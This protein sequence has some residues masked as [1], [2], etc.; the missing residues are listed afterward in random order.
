MTC[1]ALRVSLKS[2]FS[3]AAH[4]RE[5]PHRL[6]ADRHIALQPL[7]NLR[8]R[9]DV[10]RHRV[11]LLGPPYRLNRALDELSAPDERFFRRWQGSRR[12][13]EVLRRCS[14]KALV[15]LVTAKDVDLAVVHQ[16]VRGVAARGFS[17]PSAL[18]A[19]LD[20]VLGRIAL[21]CRFGFRRGEEIGETTP[22]DAER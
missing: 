1:A 22:N 5:Q 8:K 12:G 17:H 14:L 3:P 20:F 19:Q 13:R 10:A 6:G 16:K 4:S 11:K 15:A 2:R 7:L 21:E 18:T 9:F